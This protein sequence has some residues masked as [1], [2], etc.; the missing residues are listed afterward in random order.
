MLY[1]Y[2]KYDIDTF[3]LVLEEVLKVSY[4]AI[5]AILVDKTSI[6][7]DKGF[8]NPE[9]QLAPFAPVSTF[10]KSELAI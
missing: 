1:N 10:N 4:I 3:P 5:D 8:D 7:S 6:L 9:V 2:L